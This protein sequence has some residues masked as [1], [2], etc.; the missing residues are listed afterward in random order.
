MTPISTTLKK[1]K[2][3]SGNKSCIIL[4]LL[5]FLYII[6]ST[7]YLVNFDFDFYCSVVGGNEPPGG[8]TL[9]KI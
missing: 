5:F 7:F 8:C 3:V 1:K 4:L 6:F 9:A 2:K